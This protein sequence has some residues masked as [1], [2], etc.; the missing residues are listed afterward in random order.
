MCLYQ[1]DEAMI[2][3][4]NVRNAAASLAL[5]FPELSNASS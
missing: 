1:A 2:L 5:N 4:I 3:L